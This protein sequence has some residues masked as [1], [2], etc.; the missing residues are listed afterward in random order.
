MNSIL[1]LGGAA[2]VLLV[3]Y[4]TYGSWLAKQWGVNPKK[5]TPAHTQEDGIDYVPGNTPVLLGH[6][7]TSVTGPGVIQ[8][9]V[10]GAVF[11]WVPVLL[12]VVLGGIFIGAVQDFGSLFVSLRHKGRTMGQ[13]IGENMGRK[14]KFCFLIL[15]WLAVV[16]MIAAFGDMVVNS[17]AGFSVDETGGTVQNVANG[18]V[19][20]AS[21]LLIPT[22]IIFGYLDRMHCPVVLSTFFG[23]L[24]LAA[25][26]GAGLFFPIYLTSE[27]W[28][29]VI[30][31]YLLLSSLLPVWFLLQPRN[32]I[33]SYLLYFLIGASAFGIFMIWPEMK[34][35]P[36]VGWSV[37]GNTLFPYLF[38]TLVCGAASGYHSLVGSGIS[39]K[40]LNNER[41][42]KKVGYGAMMLQCLLAVIVL[43]AVGSLNANGD[44]AEYG[45]PFETFSAALLSFFQMFGLN[46]QWDPLVQI[47]ILLII[48]TMA[49]T[50]L[51]TA[52]RL[53]RTL[54]Q[55]LFTG[56]E[57]QESIVTGR[58]FTTVITLAAAWGLSFAGYERVWPILG[59]CVQL[60]TVPVC[61]GIAGWLKRMGRSNKMLYPPMVFML[62]VS[63]VSLVMIF[64]RNMDA[65][66]KDAKG[67]SL[68]SEGIQNGLLLLAAVLTV[69]MIL[70]GIK[71]L[72]KK[73]EIVF[74][75]GNE[76]K[77]K[78]IR[79]I[80]S[81]VDGEIISMKDAGV[82]ADIVE[83]GV[84]F[85]ENAIIKAKAVCKLTGKLT[86]ADDSG[87][88]IDYLDKE[89]GVYSARYMGED[90]SYSVK[91]ASLIKRLEGVPQEERTAR[92]VCVIAA[93]YPDGQV[94]T[95]RETMEGYI[96]YEERGTNGFG[97]D[98][99]FYLPEFDCSSAELDMEQKNKVSHRGKALRAIKEKLV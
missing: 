91:N 69:I 10:M 31:V 43:V 29:L 18:A 42:A 47:L 74:A 62:A 88:E 46:S 28:R 26:T 90:T 59:T 4:L 2:L 99:I 51:D 80:M 8:G 56:T 30:L 27:V 58:I 12:W 11:G 65:L 16:L 64:K 55:D 70:E 98:P 81:D 61:L 45:T 48:S 19:A 39:A 23:L 67:S 87:L 85:E 33:S 14:S 1:I 78:E 22:A 32:Y 79:E 68:W 49:F 53:G 95:A 60:L 17:F 36:F 20:M 40:Q 25:C 13:V 5:R 21:M 75:T 54:L 76:G 7:F 57:N 89:P 9:T 3:A 71:A 37:D 94:I 15:A 83:D 63:A 52:V 41:N 44:F 96:G 77:M 6:H 35:K 82:D 66:L 84:T 86:L 34:L 38:V 92:F 24:L 93:A 72:N 97:Y 73:R 50:T